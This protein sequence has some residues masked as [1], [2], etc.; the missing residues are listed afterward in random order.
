MNWSET[1]LFLTLRGRNTTVS[2]AVQRS[3]N[4][5]LPEIETILRAGG[6][7]PTRFTLHDSDHS[8]RVAQMMTS[9]AGKEFLA[10]CSEI[11]IAML[12]LAAYLHD[13]G[14]TPERNLAKLHWNYLIT[15]NKD[16]LSSEE[17]SELQLWLDAE[18]QGKEP[19][20]QSTQLTSEGL[21]EAEAIFSFYCRHKHNDW[22]ALWIAQHLTTL[23]R[24]I[25]SGW[26][27]DL[28]ALCTSHHE[29]LSALRSSKFDA[30]V[31]GNPGN[32]LNLRYLAAI[33][34]VAD[35]LEFDPERTPDVILKH[36]DIPAGSRIFWHRDHGVGLRLDKTAHQLIL[37]ARTP[38]AL[39]H[40]AVLDMVDAIDQEL[41]LCAILE[42]E[43][44]FR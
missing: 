5:C 22:S 13:I 30:R 36:R 32:P 6:T 35:I 19:P 10:S 15:G 18:W 34:R 42:R 41:S 1:D 37:S 17:Q 27:Q 39:V 4:E 3:L 2:D 25:Y 21:D 43:G 8:F 38:N 28:V 29:G 40:R 12:L 7:S 44:A 24:P 33:L 23:P 31:I 9:L 14:M 11:E 26:T 16:L 20:F